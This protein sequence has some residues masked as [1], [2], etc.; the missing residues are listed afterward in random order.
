MTLKWKG[1]LSETNHF[2]QNNVPKNATQ[3][4]NSKS[5]I[6]PYTPVIPILILVFIAVYL[7]RNFIGQFNL[8]I[9]GIVIGLI[10]T[11]PFLIIHEF[12]H[13]VCFTKD[14]TAEMFYSPVGVSIIPCVPISKLRYA[15]TLVVPAIIIGLIPLLIWTFIPFAN[16][17]LNSIIFILSIGNLG[18]T[19]NDLYNLSQ[20]I[21]EMPKGSFMITSG[22]NCYYY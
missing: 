11:I 21:K 13:A 15:I 6:K 12:L 2:P 7:K 18:G 9:K 20:V 16:T 10:L 8:D 3:F 19:T 14:C 17:T 1:L 4:L 22:I 5:K